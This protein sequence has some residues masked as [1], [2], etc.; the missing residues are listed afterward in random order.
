MEL[1]YAIDGRK[2]KIVPVKEAIIF[3]MYTNLWSKDGKKRWYIIPESCGVYKSVFTKSKYV[4]EVR[5][6]K[7][8]S[9][10]T[11]KEEVSK[12]YYRYWNLKNCPRKKGAL[13]VGAAAALRLGGSSLI[14]KKL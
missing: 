11:T 7:V 12:F 2:I 14:K 4:A 9:E 8:P 13:G 1:K 5:F 3:I 10:F 6:I